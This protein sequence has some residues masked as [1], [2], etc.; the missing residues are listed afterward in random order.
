MS[1][2]VKK[3]PIEI[4]ANGIKYE[5]PKA[6]AKSI[7]KLL[8]GHENTNKLLDWREGFKSEH[9]QFGTAGY[10]L[11]SYRAKLGL[12][13]VEL[14]KKIKT[15]QRNISAMENGKRSIGKE[16]AKRL[17]KVFKTD[18]QIFL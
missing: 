12:T 15:D 16:T 2:A 6:K 4:I 10:N 8:K 14:A 13:Q 17:A 18:Y 11:Q 5:V 3:H 1:E 9:K 7:L